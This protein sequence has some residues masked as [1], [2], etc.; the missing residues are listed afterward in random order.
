MMI[1]GDFSR[2][3][4]TYFL[5][6]KSDVPTIFAGF[7]GDIR[8]QSTPTIVECLRSDNGNELTKGE[9]VALLNHQPPY[10][11]RV[12]IS[13]LSEVRRR[14]RAQDAL[15]LEATMASFLEAPRSAACLCRLQ[16]LFGRKRAC[17]RVMPSMCRRGQVTSRTC[18]HHSRN[19]TVGHRS[20]DCSH[21]FSLA[22]TL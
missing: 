21:F 8:A 5:K 20:R 4:W 11:P 7:L 1:V 9:F 13:G 15:V 3:G 12:H 10:P 19:C 22:F 2:F 17:T 18:C 16:G 14:G 6:E